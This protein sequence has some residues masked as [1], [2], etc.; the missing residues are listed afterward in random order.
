MQ[1]SYKV[2][3]QGRAAF[4]TYGS[5]FFGRVAVDLTFNHKNLVDTTYGFKRERGY[6]DVRFTLRL[7]A[8]CRFDI[9]QIEIDAAVAA[10][11]SLKAIATPPATPAA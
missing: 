7:F 11:P 4:T 5:P 3:E 6:N 2:S 9:G 10:D 1:P 8:C